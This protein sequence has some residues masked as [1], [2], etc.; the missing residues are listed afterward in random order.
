MFDVADFGEFFVCFIVVYRKLSIEFIY[1]SRPHL[2]EEWSFREIIW[3]TANAVVW[4]S[5]VG[6]K[7][8]V[9]GIS[10]AQVLPVVVMLVP[11]RT[12]D[13]NVQL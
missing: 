4:S 11:E 1:S 3:S 2:H 6:P 13:L 7:K 5:Y 10:Q 8:K 9:S 12:Y